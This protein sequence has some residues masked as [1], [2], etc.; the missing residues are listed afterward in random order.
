MI[1]NKCQ[2]AMR[3]MLELAKR[4]AAEGPATIVEIAE[5]QQIPSRFLEAILRELKQ[6][7]LTLSIRGKKGGYA[8]AKP[9][10]EITVGA[11]VR[12][13]EGPYFTPPP[14]ET[15]GVATNRVDVFEAVWSEAADALDTVLGRIDFADLAE[16]DRVAAAPD[17]LNYSI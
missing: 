15:V 11:V 6:A 14:Q 8:L 4:Q 17:V 7:G 16:R 9:A 1:S 5:A 13:L 10:R 2:Y 12:T 3:A